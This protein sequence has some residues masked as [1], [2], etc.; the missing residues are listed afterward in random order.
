MEKVQEEYYSDMMISYQI[1]EKRK[2]MQTKLGR[3]LKW[4]ATGVAI[5]WLFKFFTT[6]R[7]VFFLSQPYSSNLDQNLNSILSAL[8]TPI[9]P[10]SEQVRFIL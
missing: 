3:L 4:I 2:F 9:A 5:F 7:N 10:G 1:E 8:P 6:I